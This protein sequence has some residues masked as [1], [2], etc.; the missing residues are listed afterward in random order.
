MIGVLAVG[1]AF[2]A[3]DRSQP[4]VGGPGPSPTPVASAVVQAR[5]YVDELVAMPDL[6]RPMDELKVVPLLDGRVLVI[7]RNDGGPGTIGYV[8]DPEDDVVLPVDV[9]PVSGGTVTMAVRLSD[10]RVLLINS[11]DAQIFDP[12]SLRFAP[13]GPMVTQRSSGAAVLLRDGRVLIAG[14]MPS[15]EGPALR[16]AELFDPD[17]GTFS[18]T[19]SIGSTT[20]GGPMVTMPDGRVYMATDPTAEVYDPS[21]GTFSAASTTSGGGGSP[22]ALPDGRVA[23]FGSTGL[24]SGGSIQVWDP[25]SSTFSASSVPE[26]LTGA[27]LLDDGRI[28]RDRHV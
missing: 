14:G 7:G 1:G 24:F 17:T 5:I 27:T 6:P 23:V 20:G 22:V 21:T 13:V 8:L 12:T 2:L 15:P 28:L 10:G 25:I 19:G 18:P 26:P 9:M 16:S 3:F 4:A 11:W